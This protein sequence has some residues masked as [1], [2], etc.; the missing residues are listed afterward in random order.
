MT[1]GF[2][3]VKHKCVTKLQNVGAALGVIE[4]W[5]QQEMA[6]MMFMSIKIN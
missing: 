1:V 4:K 2:C 5:Q 6:T 3:P